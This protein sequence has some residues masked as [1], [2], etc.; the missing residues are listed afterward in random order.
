MFDS[1]P[2]VGGVLMDS[3]MFFSDQGRFKS[4]ELTAGVKVRQRLCSKP[5]DLT[6]LASE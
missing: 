5:G 6:R 1:M 3:E 4:T 2:S